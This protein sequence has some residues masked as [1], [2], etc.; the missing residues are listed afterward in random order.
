MN[1]WAD[2]NAPQLVQRAS[3]SA[4]APNTPQRASRTQGI[5]NEVAYPAFYHT[6]SSSSKPIKFSVGDT[7]ILEAPTSQNW[8]KPPPYLVKGKGKKANKGKAKAVDGYDGWTH[9]DGLGA[10]EKVA[11]IIRL[12]EDTAEAN[13]DK[14]MKVRVRWL[15]RPGA[16]WESDGPEPHDVEEPEPFELY[17]TADSTYVHD[18]EARKSWTPASLSIGGPLKDAM[19]CATILA[20]NILRHARVVDTS[21]QR[22]TDDKDTFIV[23]MVY[24]IKPLPKAEFMGDIVWSEIHAKGI[25]YGEWDTEPLYDEDEV[26]V[27]AATPRKKPVKVGSEWSRSTNGKGKGKESEVTERAPSEAASSDDEDEDAEDEVFVLRAAHQEEVDEVSGESEGDTE[28]EGSPGPSTPR[29]SKRGRSSVSTPKSGRAAKRRAISTAVTPSRHQP[30]VTSLAKRKQEA[31]AKKQQ[32]FKDRDAATFTDIPPAFTKSADF[33]KLSPFGKAK[34]LLH[35]SATPEN[36]PGREEQ[37]QRIQDVLANAILGQSG[38]CL[39]IHG[40]PGTGKTATVHSVVRELQED[41]DTRG[42]GFVEINGMKISEPNTAFT[43]LWESLSGTKAPPRQALAH[44]EEHFQTPDPT[45]KTTVVLVDELDQMITKKQDVIYNFFNWPHVSHSR[46]IVIAIANT[47]DL[48]ERELS[49][50]IRSRLGS[51]RIT[52]QP[53][54]WQELEGILKGRL[55][56]LEVFQPIALTR[57]AKMVAGVSG[58]ARRALDVARRC[59]EKKEQQNTASGKVELVTMPD[60]G[61]TYTEMTNYGSKIFVQRASLHQKIFLLA[62]SSTIK[63]AGVPEVELEK[64]FKWHL[65]FLKQTCI[66]PVP[67][68]EDLFSIVAELHSLRLVVTESQRGDYFQRISSLVENSDLFDALKADDCELKRHVHKLG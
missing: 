61:K 44:L 59:V 3:T 66:E 40:V 15:G 2:P 31:R 17:Y 32:R 1:T 46:L 55:D 28:D 56:A 27:K 30:K 49:G 45:R 9:E 48:P 4:K 11:V 10:A 5:T 6:P 58:D 14:K 24:D 67:S 16:L 7:V 41:L 53:Y 68:H 52:F 64:V 36:L 37:R 33:K 13:V 50:K 18:L 12:F 47:M 35:V 60:V 51:N 43:L 23:R 34:A 57:V 26:V 39:Y 63:R 19:C 62:L 8:L 65:D 29:K 20:S 22:K 38:T 54:T 25:K 21:T 42:F